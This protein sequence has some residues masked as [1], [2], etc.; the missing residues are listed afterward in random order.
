MDA[1]YDDAESL[2]MEIDMDDL[3]PLDTRQTTLELGLL[4]P[5]ETLESEARRRDLRADRCH[6]RASWA[7][8]PRYSTVVGRG[9][10]A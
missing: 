5:D 7:S 1:A 3:D 4:P 9:S 8:I 10:P 6:A 2:L